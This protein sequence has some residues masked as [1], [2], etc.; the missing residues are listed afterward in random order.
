MATTET[1][2]AVA[3][4]LFLVCASVTADAIARSEGIGLA[5]RHADGQKDGKHL[6]FDIKVE[7]HIQHPG[8]RRASV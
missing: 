3:T 6:N 8:S 2:F 5:N 7:M 1:S 4:M